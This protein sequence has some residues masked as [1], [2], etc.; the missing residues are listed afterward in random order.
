MP[1]LSRSPWLALSVLAFAMLIVG[2]DTMVLTVA[3][4]TLARDLDASTT[5]LQWITTC[6]PLV[7]GAFMIPLGAVGDRFGRGRLLAI[8]LVGF[9]AA[10]ALCAFAGSPGLLIVGR[11]ALGLCAAAAMPMSMAVLP[12]LF[13]DP[14]DRTK[15]LGVWMASSAAG[16]PLGPILGGVLLQHFWWG[17]VFL[18]NVPIAA[19]AAVAVWYLIPNSKARGSARFDLIGVVGSVAGFGLLVAAFTQAGESGW[20]STQFIV[21]IAVAA[22][23]TAAFVVY[24]LTTA[25]PLVN[26]HLFVR[27]GFLAG[28]VLASTTMILLASATFQLA[29]AFAVAFDADALGVGLR[30]LPII[31]GLILGTRL[32][33]VA[34]DR[35]GGRATA[36]VAVGLLAASSALQGLR[37]DGGT[38]VYVIIAALLGLGLGII[39]PLAMTLALNDLDAADAGSGSALL[40]SI[41]QISAALGVAVFGSIV[42][43]VYSARLDDAA[44]PAPLRAGTSDNVVATT[45]Q[46]RQIAPGSVHSVVDAYQ[47][48]LGVAGLIG[49]GF[50]AVLLTLCVLIPAQ[51]NGDPQQRGTDDAARTAGSAEGSDDAGRRSTRTP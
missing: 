49:V 42:A 20:A 18:I 51:C 38:A 33:D 9:G 34:V 25:H 3:L 16:M 39:L 37:P 6:Y 26:L 28:T 44:L 1:R 24:E 43:A 22:V 45:A 21:L 12:D 30:L 47:H 7:L 8:S 48:A 35:F 29:Q 4:P 15:A 27:R 41:R 13:A 17:S 11:V 46:L 40:Q 14:A 31:G 23:V 5:E 10:S 32:T 36:M 50:T 2:L 19:L